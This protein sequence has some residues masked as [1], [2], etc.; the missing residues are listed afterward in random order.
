MNNLKFA[1]RQLRN[2]PGFTAVAMLTLALGIGS[3]TA[4]FSVV[5]AV[6]LRPLPFANMLFGVSATDPLIFAIKAAIMIA[7]AA[8]ACFVPARRA[9]KVD[10]IEALR[11]E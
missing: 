11:Y 1:F 3:C 4:M 2:D 5:R 7:V 6:L 9:T 8:F 10:P